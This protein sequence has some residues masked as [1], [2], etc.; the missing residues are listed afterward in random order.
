MFKKIA[1]LLALIVTASFATWDYYPIPKEGVG[2]VE[3]GFYYDA[4]DKHFNGHDD[5]SQM[6]LAVGARVFLLQKFELSV[7]NWGY[8]FWNERDCYKCVNGG[9]G[10]RDLTI[11]GRFAIDPMITAFIDFNLPTGRTE[12]DG[13]ET[14][15]PSK[16]E[17]SI[18]LGAQFS[19]DT[20]VP[21]FKIGSE[22]GIL[23]GFEHDHF[24]RGLEMHVGIEAGYTIPKVGL[25]P[26]GG[27]Q[28]KLRIF[29]SEWDDGHTEYGYDDNGSTQ[30]NLWFGGSYDV[31][32]EIFVKM[33]FIYR[34]QR[35]R[36][37]HDH[38]D[39]FSMMDGDAWGIY[40]GAGINF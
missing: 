35:Y 34:N 20:K 39:W 4:Y 30:F 40:L 32:K 27:F 24:E 7:Q 8:Q 31:T 12:H 25:T 29:E 21:G 11:G 23:W 2:T 22:A 19:V 36:G 16:N 6:G 13:G 26:Y 3:A 38:Y 15:P 5:W 1:L 9:D 37:Y 33:H 10:V 18:Y 17:F 28:L 14:N